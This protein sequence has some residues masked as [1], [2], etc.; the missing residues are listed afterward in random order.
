MD[1]VGAEENPYAAPSPAMIADADALDYEQA[2]SVITELYDRLRVQQDASF[3]EIR[4]QGDQVMRE[5][6]EDHPAL[7]PMMPNLTR[8]LEIRREAQ[9]NRD[10]TVIAVAISAFRYS[11]GAWPESIDDA[12]TAIEPEPLGR[13]YYGRDFVYRIV[14][15]APLLYV[16]GSNRGDDG[17]RGFRYESR[18]E[19]RSE[20]AADDVLFLVPSGWSEDGLSES[21]ADS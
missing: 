18:R 1:E 8:A 2:I 17:G 19:A 15:D 7:D 21:D 20:G 3:R 9:L 10:A 14:D 11:Q 4:T 16:I 5:F 12:L 13:D 6:Q